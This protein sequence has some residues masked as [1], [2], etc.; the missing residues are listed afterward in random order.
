MKH[1][2][3]F[4]KAS[5]ALALGLVQSAGWAQAQA[6]PAKPITFIV[7]YA[8]GS[9]ADQLV[10]VTSNAIQKESGANFII[11]NLPGALGTIGSAALVR[12]LADGYTLGLCS[13]S[14]NSISPS[15]FKTLP[16]DPIRDFTFVEPL[17]A[18]SFVLSSAT[19]LGYK[20]LDDLIHDAKAHPEKLSY[21][22]PNATAQVLGAMVKKQLGIEALGVPYKAS[23]DSLS[24]LSE[25]RVSFAITDMGVT[26]PMVRI[27]RAKPL[28][29]LGPRRSVNLPEVPTFAESGKA[30]IEVL[31]WAGI[32]GPKGM[33]PE[34][35]KWVRSQMGR[36]MV[37][38]ELLAQL[39][40]LGL[41]PLTLSSD[42]FPEFATQQLTLWTHA[43]RDAGIQSE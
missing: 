28:A 20:T 2:G 9:G 36:A 18:Y 22:Y 35:V 13:A 15:L 11:R 37:R 17:V 12:S 6:Y 21:A 42:S 5:M 25:N 8:T 10:R 14:L 1:R 19:A 4:Y 40:M 43:A 3:N 41:D 24:D 34:A 27:G 32:C 31:A 7:Q 39:A 29:V 26:A 16:Y 33:P 38:P 30:P 23:Q